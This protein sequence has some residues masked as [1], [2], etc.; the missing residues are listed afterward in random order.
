M[1]VCSAARVGRLCARLGLPGS[2]MCA[3]ILD[4]QAASLNF[5]AMTNVAALHRASV[6]ANMFS[7]GHYASQP[8]LHPGQQFQRVSCFSAAAGYKPPSREQLDLQNQ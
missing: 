4:A 7:G 5:C 8:S 2:E 6:V 3:S 1:Y